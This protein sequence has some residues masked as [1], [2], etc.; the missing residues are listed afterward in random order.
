MGIAE[1][2]VSG[3]QL[4]YAMTTAHEHTGR[5]RHCAA[6]VRNH[7]DT[8]VG[9]ILRAQTATDTVIFDHDLQVF[10]AMDGIDGTAD[11]AMRVGARSAGSGDQIIVQART[12]PK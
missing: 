2:A 9:T 11:H 7:E 1:I 4:G 6:L 10:A 12:G 3:F 8:A 5:H